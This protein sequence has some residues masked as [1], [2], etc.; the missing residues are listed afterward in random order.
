MKNFQKT[1]RRE[2]GKAT[3]QIYPSAFLLFFLFLSL[4]AFF[5]STGVPCR[6]PRLRRSAPLPLAPLLR[7]LLLLRS[8]PLL[9]LLCL[10]LLPLL[11]SLLLL[12]P[13]ALFLRL[14]AFCFW[15]LLPPDRPHA[16]QQVP[17][18]CL[19]RFLF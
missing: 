15:Q 17:L 9:L 12:L 19:R 7:L 10:L 3:K 8:L 4:Q 11:L 16:C 1:T 13:S 2:Q 6:R 5:C 14:F 18:R